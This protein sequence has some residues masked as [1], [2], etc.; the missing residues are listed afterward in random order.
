MATR[1]N[2]V[3]EDAFFLEILRADVAVEMGVLPSPDAAASLG[4]Y[5]DSKEYR[6]L[7]AASI[8]PAD[9]ARVETEVQRIVE[10]AGDVRKAV[11]QRGVA[12]DLPSR[13]D[14]E[15][16]HALSDSGARL[17]APL[18][19]MD[20]KRYMG[21]LPLG[22]GGMG[23][24]Y[25][26]LDTELNRRVAFKM[27]HAGTTGPLAHESGP[28]AEDTAARFVQEAVVTGG[29]EHP[30]IVPVYELGSTP[31]G[32]P[33]YTMRV[34]RGERTLDDAV[35][36]VKT[37]EHR[38]NLLEPFLKVCDTVGYAHSRGVIHR[39]LKPANVAL[40]PYGEVVVLDWGL[41]KMTSQP[42]AEGTRWQ[43]RL[44]T[45]REETS[46]KTLTSALGTPGFM[47]PE[48]ALGQVELVDHR[49]DIYSLGAI[50]H[51]ILTGRFPFE[52]TTYPQFLDGVRRGI[53]EVPG[54]PEGLAGICLTAL[55]T[56]R[57]ERYASVGELATAIRGWL[58][59]SSVERE[60]DALV[61]EAGLALEA[62]VG[63]EGDALLK[64]L[65]HAIAVAARALELRPGE[66]MAEATQEEARNLR[67]GAIEHREST[68]RRRVMK[69][70]A[71]VG[72][73]LATAATI[74]VALLLDGKRREAEDARAREAEQ[75][76]L[77]ED[78]RGRAQ[79]MAR[80][81]LTDLREGLKPMGRLDLLGS[82]ASKSLEYYEGLPEGSVT[83][84]VRR[85]H[86]M[87][88]AHLSEALVDSGDLAGALEAARSSQRVLE[89]LLA[90]DPD[91]K[92]LQED[93]ALAVNVAGDA[94]QEGGDLAA[95][96]ASY[97][98]SVE[99]RRKLAPKD[100]A[101][102][103]DRV[104]TVLMRMGERAPARAIFEE[105]LDIRRRL[106]AEDP[107][108][109]ELRRSL[110]MSVESVGDVVIH[111]EGLTAAL[112]RYNE[113]LAIRRK[114]FEEVPNDAKARTD[115]AASLFRVAYCLNEE[116][117]TE[118]SRVH[119]EESLALY[120]DQGR[121]TPTDMWV[122]RNIALSLEALGNMAQGAG[123]NERARANFEEA[124]SI[125]QGIAAR[126]RTNRRARHDVG[127]AY[128]HLGDIA[129]GA[130]DPDAALRSYE[131]ALGIAR[132]LVA[133]DGDNTEWKEDLNSALYRYGQACRLKSMLPEAQVAFEEALAVAKEL[134][135]KDP[136]NTS[137]QRDVALTLGQLGDVAAARDR[138]EDARARHAESLTIKRRL[139]GADSS[140]LA[141][142][143]D[144]LYGLGRLASLARDAGENDEAIALFEETVP[145]HRHVVAADPTPSRRRELSLGLYNV[146]T[147]YETVGRADDALPLLREAE[148]IHRGLAAWAHEHH[149]WQG[150][151]GRVALAVGP[152]T[153]REH[154]EAAYL[155]YE[156][157]DFERSADHYAEAL[158]DE[159]LATDLARGNRYN[160][161]CSAALAGQPERAM[162]WLAADLRQRRAEHSGERLERH[163]EHAREKDPD[164]ASLRELPAFDELFR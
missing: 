44:K 106:V 131:K 51:K 64:Q 112:E 99:L 163:L 32:V 103:L 158:A 85:S 81:M 157:K 7:G 143:S 62:A 12:R 116:G 162:M 46:L 128:I 52:F 148:T 38:L 66:T 123:D 127:K 34:V 4:R 27:V 42:D 90:T 74:L 70:V 30:G 57:D 67:D 65:D 119:Y 58:T 87:A 144:L 71:I 153:P 10:A 113:S 105:S 59:E 73:G 91:N 107:T 49:S 94:E 156:Q 96:L 31:A 88:L 33:Y 8:T 133:E 132:E 147:M 111:A 82:V 35:R 13:L 155:L 54:V 115:L 48:A 124:L 19:R 68:A 149:Y 98:R 26:A 151:L 164:L 40:G 14:A 76:R 89:E 145:I 84:E 93:L 22:E 104:A 16:A 130:G 39:D 77:A 28:V 9:R 134:T 102:S 138:P 122:Q 159:E 56:E 114:V 141:F 121:L 142:R 80:F 29:L 137:W 140:N 117:N 150:A 43:S 3:L 11:A 61:K 75:R 45:L 17:R 95:A 97:R 18:R 146:G 15:T 20:E 129:K 2:S 135:A 152:E 83:P 161:A 79:E 108:N 63:M 110:S 86:A 136:R 25:L 24:V 126:D 36:D 118:A 100:L 37:V 53:T 60:V 109:V 5:W 125:K 50:L 41:A 21:F 23:I 1:E 6:V 69:R 139:V 120:R 72:M 154:L 92:G 101:R 78:E 55:A 47:S 160:A